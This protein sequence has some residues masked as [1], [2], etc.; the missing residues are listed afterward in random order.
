[1]TIKQL[2]LL[3]ELARIVKGLDTGTSTT[4]RLDKLMMEVNDESSDELE[5]EAERD[6]EEK[7]AADAEAAEEAED[8]AAAE[9][10]VEES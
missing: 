5:A 1:M 10:A 9:E 8:V 6:R 4:Q 3:L 2:M 7:E